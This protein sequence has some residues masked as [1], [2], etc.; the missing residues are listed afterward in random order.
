MFIHCLW[1][2]H[3]N[4]PMQMT[5]NNEHNNAGFTKWLEILNGEEISLR[6]LWSKNAG[7][8]MNF[9]ASK[10]PMQIGHPSLTTATPFN[11][12]DPF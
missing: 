4:F 8:I 3:E 5:H 1:V 6:L 2:N 11:V 12:P 9:S 7:L 10:G